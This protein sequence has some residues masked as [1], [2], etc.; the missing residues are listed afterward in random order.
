MILFLLFICIPLLEIAVF[1]AVGD[2]IG[3]GWTLALCV[4]TALLGA[5]FVRHQGLHALAGI[6]QSLDAGYLPAQEMFDGI[7]LL[8]AGAFLMTPGFVTDALGFSLLVPPFRR[9]IQAGVGKYAKNNA[10]YRHYTSGPGGPGAKPGGP[11]RR[12]DTII[13]EGDYERV[14]EEDGGESTSRGGDSTRP[15]ISD[16]RE[17]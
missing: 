17:E 5:G 15:N 4:I 13:I 10:R 9:L 8:A 12:E 14:D 1:I 11:G 6:R 3:V 2:E 16:N 7:C